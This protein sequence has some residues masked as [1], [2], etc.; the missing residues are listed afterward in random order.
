MRRYRCLIVDDED[1]IIE[2]LKGIF[3]RFEDR[4]ELVGAAYSGMEALKLAEE[5]QP[6]IVLTDIVMPRMDGMT[7]IAAMKPAYPS[8]VFII[9]TAYSD[10]EYAKQAIQLGVNDYIIKVPLEEQEIRGALEKAALAIGQKEKLDRELL[11]LS[12]FRLEHVYRL[13]RQMFGELLSGASAHRQI[14]DMGEE[15]RLTFRPEQ[16]FAFAMEDSDYR[17]FAALYN[18]KDRSILQYALLNITEETLSQQGLE[19]LVLELEDNRILGLASVSGSPGEARSHR[20]AMELGQALMGN[21]G[22]FL[23]RRMNVSFSRTAFGWEALRSVCREA[24]ERLG[25]SYYEKQGVV[26]HSQHPFQQDPHGEEWVEKV[27]RRGLDAL[28]QDC[29]DKV[30]LELFRELEEHAGKKRVPAQQMTQQLKGLLQGLHLHVEERLGSSSAPCPDLEEL[31]F[32]SQL[33]LCRSY[34]R[35]CQERLDNTRRPEIR[36]AKQYIAAHLAERCSLDEIA[37]HVGLNPSYLSTL[38]KREEGETLV[39][40]TNRCRIE[41]AL[42]LLKQGDYSNLELSEMVGIMNERYFCTLFKQMYGLPPQKY[43]KKR[44]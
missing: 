33:E 19:G 43:R 35:S 39:D 18:E 42:E 17:S 13:R 8:A 23:K 32:L 10:F 29:W 30:W 3:R 37:E 4:F 22:L 5:R 44:L 1:L 2:R 38:F 41:K 16:Y 14:Q 34:I 24:L 40:Y 12:R 15:L 7:L 27:A 21:I 36:K 20:Q 11:R 28:K 26:L 6:D 31:P 25:A 9:L